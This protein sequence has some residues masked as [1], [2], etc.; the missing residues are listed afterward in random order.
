MMNDSMGC[1]GDIQMVV[2]KMGRVEVVEFKNTVLRTGREALALCLANRL[3]GDF[4]FFVSKMLFGDGG[5]VAGSPKSVSADRTALFGT[6]RVNKPVISNIDPNNGSQVIFTSVVSYDEG[7]G[8]DINEM[9]LQLHGSIIPSSNT[10]SL[11]SMATF[12]GISK[13]SLMQLTFNWRISFI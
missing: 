4:D 8:F 7:N 5:S 6:T 9:A 2:E 3:G 13:T 1:R 10:P 11:Y 12:P